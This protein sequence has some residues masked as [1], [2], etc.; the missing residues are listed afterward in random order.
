MKTSRLIDL[1]SAQ[2]E[3]V[4]RGEFW[5]ALALALV[6]GAMAAFGVMLVTLGERPA[7]ASP[8]HFEFIALKVGLAI[9]V[10]ATAVRVLG[11]LASPGGERIRFF[12]YFLAL[13]AVIAAGAAIALVLTNSPMPMTMPGQQPITCI[14]CIP[15]FAILPFGGLIWALRQAAPTDLRRAGAIAGLLAGGVGAAVYAFHCPDDSL[16]FVVVWYGS[17]LAFC[18]FVGAWLGP[19]LLRW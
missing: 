18:T 14:L 12:P 2:V 3:P 10:I 19:K 9:A 5:K 6:L 17:A 7:M 16:L 13:F 1:L 8:Q 15:L 4:R 11:R